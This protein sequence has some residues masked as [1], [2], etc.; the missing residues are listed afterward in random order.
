MKAPLY[1]TSRSGGRPSKTVLANAIE[2][3]V[4]TGVCPGPHELVAEVFNH[5]LERGWVVSI[6]ID[7]PY[8]VVTRIR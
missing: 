8:S 5:G 3:F 4:S 6:K 2:H 1:L 7:G